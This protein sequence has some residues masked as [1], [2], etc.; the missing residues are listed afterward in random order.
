M[1]KKDIHGDD[2]IMP[3]ENASETYTTPEGAKV[4]SVSAVPKLYMWVNSMLMYPVLS[5]YSRQRLLRTLFVILLLYFRYC[6]T[7]P[8]DLFTDLIPYWF[9]DKKTGI[10]SV[11]LPSNTPIRT[12]IQVCD[13]ALSMYGEIDFFFLVEVSV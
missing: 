2:N 6:S 10:C 8:K 1:H 12:R 13:E 9:Y 5:I 11:K 4:T 7:L 3:P